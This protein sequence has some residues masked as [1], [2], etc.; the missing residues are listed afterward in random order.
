[1]GVPVGCCSNELCYRVCEGRL[2]VYVEDGIRVFAVNHTA[3]G[4]NDGY[5]VYAS[6]FEKR[7]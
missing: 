7:C 3:G 1:M 4:K 6:V 2:W 5:E